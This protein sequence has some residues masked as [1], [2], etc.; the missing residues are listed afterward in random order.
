MSIKVVT[1]MEKLRS[2]IKREDGASA[3]EYA[4]IAGLIAVVIIGGAQA[5][6]LELSDIFT[7]IK[8]TLSGARTDP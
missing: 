8:D 5:I 3:I 1:M 2:F 7:T 4:L 6:G